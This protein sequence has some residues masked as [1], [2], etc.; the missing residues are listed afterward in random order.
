MSFNIN[1]GA[2]KARLNLGHLNLRDVV[3]NMGVGEMEMDL[4][5]KPKQNYDVKISGGVGHATVHL[6]NNVGVYAEASGGIGHI[7]VK[8]LTKR[9]DH[10]ENDAYAT[11]PVKI[12]VNV[13]GGVG[14]IQ[15]IGSDE[16]PSS[17][18]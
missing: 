2:G 16:E 4:R 11:S 15:L 1:F 13:S 9:D 18:L 12:H 5:G 17:E 8:G 14:E 7:D 10:W 3:V 6:P